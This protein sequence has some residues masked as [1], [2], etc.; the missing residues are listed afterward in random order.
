MKKKYFAWGNGGAVGGKKRQSIKTRYNN[1][2]R[3]QF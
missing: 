2:K 3:Q 1:K